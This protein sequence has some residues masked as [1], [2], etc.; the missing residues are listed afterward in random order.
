MTVALARKSECFMKIP[1]DGV[2][3]ES[4]LKKSGLV[5]FGKFRAP[6]MEADTRFSEANF[7]S[8][9]RVSVSVTRLLFKPEEIMLVERTS[10]KIIARAELFKL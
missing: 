6:Y 4:V 3:V 1:M 2:D 7:S 9:T 10:R 5:I 8:P